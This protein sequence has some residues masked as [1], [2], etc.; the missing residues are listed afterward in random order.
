MRIGDSDL[1]IM[2]GESVRGQECLAALHVYVKDCDATYQR[3]LDAGAV[4]LGGL[5]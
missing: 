2:G 4:T 5:A 1:L 3:A